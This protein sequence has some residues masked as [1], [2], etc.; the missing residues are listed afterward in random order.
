MHLQIINPLEYPN[1]DELLLTNGQSTFFHTSAW[2]K[3]LCES[4]NYRPL[5]FT[6]IEDG[7]LSALIP[8]ME[9]NSFLTGKRGVSLPFTDE[10][11]PI[12]GNIEQ[13]QF[14]IEYVFEYGKK[15][16]WKHIE[17]RGHHYGF[18]QAPAYTFHYTH[19]LDLDG[20]EDRIF[21]TFKSNVKQNIK[22]ERKEQEARD[23]ADRIEREKRK[24][25][26]RMQVCAHAY[27]YAIISMPD[28]HYSFP[29]TPKCLSAFAARPQGHG[30][31]EAEAPVYTHDLPSAAST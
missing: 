3:V 26:K 22:R 24:M 29:R 14:M 7:K 11:Q 23:R 15:A 12:A 25:Q 2:A 20:D 19:V 13:F 10:C 30:C 4:Y 21:S 31:G 1:W 16:G 9:I 17:F 28:P 8:V 18:D 6:T 27:I 5:Y